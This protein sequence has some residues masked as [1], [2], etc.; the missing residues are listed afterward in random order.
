MNLSRH[1]DEDDDSDDKSF[2]IELQ[3]MAEE[4]SEKFAIK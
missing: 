4:A 2:L 3:K 1:D